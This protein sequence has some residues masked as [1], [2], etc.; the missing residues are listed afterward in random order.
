MSAKKIGHNSLIL[1]IF[2]TLALGLFSCGGP[3]PKENAEKAVNYLVNGELESFYNL[4]SQKD[5][6]TI[7]LDNFVTLY[8][9]PEYLSALEEVLPSIRKDAFKA[10]DFKETITGESAVV[11]YVLTLPDMDQLGKGVF[12]IA[13]MVATMRDNKLKS[14]NDL[15]RNYQ[16]RI[17]EYVDKNGIP[18]RDTAQQINMIRENDEWHVDLN[19]AQNLN[20]KEGIV[21]FH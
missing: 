2:S 3:S 19:L 13:D 4:L 10:K 9:G 12:T 14:E 18:T 1:A 6:E 21:L 17:K 15:I 7:T 8:K 11:T 20:S 16:D 5:K